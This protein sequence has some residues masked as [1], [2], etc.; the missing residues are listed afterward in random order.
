MDPITRMVAAG[1]AG[2]AGSSEPGLYVDDLFS[3]FLYEGTSSNQVISNGLNLGSTVRS[4]SAYSS[5]LQETQPGVNFNQVGNV[6][7]YNSG[8]TWQ[9]VITNG[10]L[11]G[12]N[13]DYLYSN[14]D[15]LDIYVDMGEAVVAT[16]F[17]IAPQGDTS[18]GAVYNTPSTV[19]LYGSNNPTNGSGWTQIYDTYSLSSS[20]WTVGELKEF[21]VSNSTAY[22]YYRLLSD[23]YKSISEWQITHTLSTPGEGGLVWI[24]NRNSNGDHWLFDTE[25]GPTKGL[26]ITTDGEF[27]LSDYFSSFDSDG[28]TVGSNGSTN[29]DTLTYASW[30]FRKAPGFFDV[31]TYTGSGSAQTISHNL[32][33]VPGMIIV[34]RVNH[35]GTQAG[36]TWPVWHRSIS[37]NTSS[38]LLLNEA[39]EAQGSSTFGTTMT[40]T[41]FSVGTSPDTNNSGSTY[42]AYIFGHDDQSFGTSGAESIIKC[43]SY[44]G[45]GSESGNVIDLGFEPQWLMIKRTSDTDPWLIWDTMRGMANGVQ[46]PYLRPNLNNA[47]DV[48]A[49]VNVLPTGF[50]LASST[51]FQNSSGQTYIYM[52]IRRPH[53]PPTAGT[54]VFAAQAS[55]DA[56]DGTPSELTYTSNFPV[57]LMFNIGRAGNSVNMPTVDRLRGNAYLRTSQPD[58]ESGSPWRLDTNAGVYLDGNFGATSDHGGLMFRRAPG[59]FDMVAYSGTGSNATHN[60]N[61]NAVPEL[62]IVKARNVS[63]EHWW[64]YSSVTGAEKA[65]KFNSINSEDSWSGYWNNTAPTSS[66]FSTTGYDGN[67]GTGKT[68]IAYLFAS[69]DGISKVG[70]YTGTGSN[71]NVDCGFTAGARFVM[72]KRTNGSFTSSGGWYF[73]DTARGIVSGNDPYLLFNST[74]AEVTNTDYIY[75]LNAGFTVTSSAPAELNTSGGTYLF[76]AIA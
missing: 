24:K 9:E 51:G 47:E 61:L 20:D 63:S 33:S 17:S 12:T 70:S 48:F 62:I 72:I 15:A 3:T 16:A 69:L 53:K 14:A 5:T 71:I 23:T 73:W 59:F 11:S 64:V 7:G 67:N 46:D 55:R 28:F 44:T 38:R 2:A 30:S 50:E 45:N 37:T 49:G 25:R 32:G 18:N 35:N 60:H 4:L 6:S 76:L 29:Y 22:R 74:A 57:D 68:Y 43:G 13:S 1:A 8:I 19:K 75:P 58:G 27:T 21:V 66:V 52:A 26:R 42:V 41:E 34:H 31:V 65:L 40:S 54:E 36:G 56:A 10:T 39:T